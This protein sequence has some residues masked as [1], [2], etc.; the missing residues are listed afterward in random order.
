M[1]CLHALDDSTRTHARTPTVPRPPLHGHGGGLRRTG[2][3][4][5]RAVPL[6]ARHA[7]GDAEAAVRTATTTTTHR[8]TFHFLSHRMAPPSP[9]PPHH[10]RPHPTATPRTGS[11]PPSSSA[12]STRSAH[13]AVTPRRVSKH[14]TRTHAPLFAVVHERGGQTPALPA[15]LSHSLG[16]RSIHKHLSPPTPSHPFP[17]PCK[18]LIITP[19]GK[20]RPPTLDEALAILQ[21]C[22]T[23][24]QR[25][26]L[27][28]GGGGFQVKA[29]DRQGCRRLS[30]PTTKTLPVR[31][32][33]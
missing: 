23:E 18:T 12:S 11:R 20:P 17:S 24:L 9:D 5:R 16:P 6:L 30:L 22:Q 29:V 10:H 15:S 25:R 31:G 33:E 7:G 32:K 21:R 8:S 28:N 27:V 1:S 19:T 26:F 14:D 3:A 13:G 2:R 4:T